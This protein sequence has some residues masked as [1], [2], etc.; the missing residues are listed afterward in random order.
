[1][2]FLPL[3]IVEYDLEPGPDIDIAIEAGTPNSWVV[4][5]VVMVEE[6]FRRLSSNRGS[7]PWTGGRESGCPE[8]PG[9]KS[10]CPSSREAGLLGAKR[11][12]D[13]I[14]GDVRGM[15]FVG[16]SGRVEGGFEE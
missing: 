5:V 10:G 15:V 11:E 16:E 2:E 4:V 14:G 12:G 6:D 7:K 13:C 3:G 8:K 9:G 1:M